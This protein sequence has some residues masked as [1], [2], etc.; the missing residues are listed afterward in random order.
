VF[1]LNMGF[2]RIYLGV[3]SIDQ[4]VYGFLIGIWSAFYFHYC[5]RENIIKHIHF[6][7]QNKE[8]TLHRLNYK[9]YLAF[10][11]SLFLF[12][13]LSQLVVYLI[14]DNVFTPPA[15]WVLNLNFKCGTTPVNQSFD[16]KSMVQAG[17][18]SVGY[19]AYLGILLY[20]KLFD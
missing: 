11:T 17:V 16:K 3:H 20:R 19:G 9:K 15:R 2:A 7:I 13:M 12:G 6:L 4:V 5:L 18:F 1:G 8:A 14:V 10:S